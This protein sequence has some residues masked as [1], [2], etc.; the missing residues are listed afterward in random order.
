MRNSGA[1]RVPRRALF[2]PIT[3]DIQEITMSD[4]RPLSGLERFLSLFTKVQA[5]EGR[6]IAIL[7][8]TRDCQDCAGVKAQFACDLPGP[9]LEPR[10]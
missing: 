2:S 5:G 10:E 7:C 4:V 9:R 1:R 3:P 6:C 8:P